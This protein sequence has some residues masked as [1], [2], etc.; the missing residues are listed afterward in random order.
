MLFYEN[1]VFLRRQLMHCLKRHNLC[2]VDVV[3]RLHYHE[4]NQFPS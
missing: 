3:M 1:N 4:M 2:E